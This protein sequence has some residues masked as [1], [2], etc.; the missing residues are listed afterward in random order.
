M[1]QN[2]QW[3]VSDKHSQ[4]NSRVCCAF[5]F[6]FLTLEELGGSRKRP[7]LWRGVMNMMRFVSRFRTELLLYSS[8]CSFFPISLSAQSTKLNV[9][10]A[11]TTRFPNLELCA[12]SEERAKKRPPPPVNLR[13]KRLHT[14]VVDRSSQLIRVLTLICWVTPVIWLTFEKNKIKIVMQHKDFRKALYQ[15]FSCTG[16]PRKNTLIKFL[17]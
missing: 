13:K 4:L 16:C 12:V 15:L 11:V 5:K 14:L 3:G 8:S 7:S 10:D 9:K 6:F 17:D 1:S 2:S